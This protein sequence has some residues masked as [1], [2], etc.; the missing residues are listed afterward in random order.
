MG[1]YMIDRSEGGDGESVYEDR[2]I[3]FI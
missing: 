1:A 2:G 3:F